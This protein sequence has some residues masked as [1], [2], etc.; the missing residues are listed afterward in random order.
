MTDIPYL[1]QLH[2]K[3]ARQPVRG[4]LPVPARSEP[5]RTTRRPARLVDQSV[6]AARGGLLGRIVPARDARRGI[7]LMA[8]LGPCRALARDES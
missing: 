2:A 8:I 6:P 1:D 4:P 5:P 7:V 3:Q